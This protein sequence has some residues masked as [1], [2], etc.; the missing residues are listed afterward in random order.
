MNCSRLIAIV[1]IAVGLSA[2]AAGGS[3]YTGAVPGNLCYNGGTLGAVGS[4]TSSG[5]SGA[6][7]TYNNALTS[8][9]ANYWVPSVASTDAGI[10]ACS[11]T[12]AEVPAQHLWADSHGSAALQP[13]ISD[14][15]KFLANT[16][17]TPA[18]I[19]ELDTSDA[20]ND[21]S[22]IPPLP[23]NFDAAGPPGSA[24]HALGCLN[25]ESDWTTGVPFMEGKLHRT[26]AAFGNTYYYGDPHGGSSNAVSDPN[27]FQYF[28]CW[29]GGLTLGA[30][31]G[32][33]YRKW[34]NPQ[35]ITT[36]CSSFTGFDKYMC[37]WCSSPSSA[38]VGDPRTYNTTTGTTTA[39][40]A[41]SGFGY[42][43]TQGQFPGI[44]NGDFET[45]SLTPWTPSGVAPTIVAVGARSGTYAAQLGSL[46]PS[47]GDSTISQTFTVPAG[48]TTV[49]FWYKIVC[50]DSLT[51]DWFVAT[52]TDTTTS[53][54][55]TMVPKTCSNNGSWQQATAP[56]TAGHTVQL[57]LTSHG[58]LAGDPTYTLIDDVSASA[59]SSIFASWVVI[60]YPPM[61][62][63]VW[64]IAD[65]MVDNAMT[66]LTGRNFIFPMRREVRALT[67]SMPSNSCGTAS[68][69]LGNG[70]HPPCQRT[71]PFRGDS[72]YNSAFNAIDSQ[73]SA[74]ASGTAVGN[75]VPI[76]GG[77]SEAASA[78]ISG[79]LTLNGGGSSPS[80]CSTCAKNHIISIA[81][82]Q[83]C[84]DP[85]T[86]TIP[87]GNYDS[88]VSCS[89]SC[90]YQAPATVCPLR[91]G[92]ETCDGSPPVFPNQ[93]AS[94]MAN[95][96]LLPT[97]AGV[98][99]IATDAIG[100][101]SHSFNLQ[102]AAAAGGGVFVDAS[103]DPSAIHDALFSVL[104]GLIHASVTTA[105]TPINSVQATAG[106]EEEL[107][108]QFL[109]LNGESVWDGHLFKT[110]LFSEFASGCATQN[111]LV[112]FPNANSS[113]RQI[114][115]PCLGGKCNG[116][117]NVDLNN[118]IVLRAND[119]TLR[120]LSPAQLVTFYS[121]NSRVPTQQEMLSYPLFQPVW[122]TGAIMASASSPWY[123]RRTYTAID[124][125]GDGKIDATDGLFQIIAGSTSGVSNATA[126]SLTPYLGIVGTDVC[127]Q[128]AALNIGVTY[129]DPVNQYLTCAKAVLN[130]ALGQDLFDSNGNGSVIDNRTHML[131]DIYHSTPIDVGPPPQEQFCDFNSRRCAATLFNVY[132]QYDGA[133]YQV[134]DQP[135]VYYNDRGVLTSTP[136]ADSY[137][138]WVNNRIFNLKQSQ[139]RVFG[140]NDGWIHAIQFACFTGTSATG[141]PQYY[142]GPGST[143]CTNTTFSNGQEIW[144]FI[145]PDLLST[146]PRLLLKKH[147][148]FNDLTPMVRDIYSGTGATKGINDF[149][150]VAIFGERNGGT[151]WSALDVTDPANPTFRWLFPQIGSIDE[152]R[153]GLSW[154]EYFP[155]SPP[156]VPIRLNTSV[157][158]APVYNGQS[159]HETWVTALPGGYD[160][161]GGKGHGVWIV[162]AYTGKKYWEAFGGSGAQRGMDF[163][164]AAFPS[165][166]AWGTNESAPSGILNKGFFDTMVIGDVGGQ[167]WT[168]RFNDIPTFANNANGDRL[169]T[170]WTIARSFQQYKG[171]DLTSPAGTYV[172]KDRVPFFYMPSIGRMTD[173]GLMR[174][175][176]G[177]GDRGNIG[178]Q[179]LGDCSGSNMLACG[180]Q[181]VV[182]MAERDEDI[183]TSTLRG[184]AETFLGDVNATLTVSGTVTYTSSSV[185]QCTPADNVLNVCMSSS[186]G[187]AYTPPAPNQPQV[188]C[189]HTGNAASDEVCAR[190]RPPDL[191][192]GTNFNSATGSLNGGS[193]VYTPAGNGYYGRFYGITLFKAGGARALFSPTLANSASAYDTARVTESGATCSTNPAG[194]CNLW[195]NGLMASYVYPETSTSFNTPVQTDGASD[196]WYFYYP[197]IDERTASPSLLADGCLLW[198]TVQ[199]TS[200]CASDADCA[201]FSG[202]SSVASGQCNTVANECDRST[203]CNVVGGSSA[204]HI[205]QINPL[206]GSTACALTQSTTPRVT[207]GTILPPPPPQVDNEVNAQG[208]I[209]RSVNLPVGLPS[210]LLT[211][212]A[213]SGQLFRTFYDLEIPR[214][215]HD[216]RHNPG[217]NCQ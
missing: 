114:A 182:T 95:N 85:G 180:K 50:P 212:Q 172:M 4:A 148:A 199:P 83:T 106:G 108:P 185:T 48:A 98:Q 204:G 132:N 15:D 31:T 81:T 149:H 142:G 162:D 133:N 120:V 68:N 147:H 164:F 42:Y 184:G 71:N 1:G 59:N 128:L 33:Q 37:I 6:T 16:G 32:Y 23:D 115:C 80:W 210:T 72:S 159:F 53:S 119:G 25:S 26:W 161:F 163:P 102:Q 89:G 127:S 196:G 79:G 157:T 29:N 209:Q 207:F 169:A 197:N 167:L 22:T 111:G 78:Y 144:A 9:G 77:L 73:F 56:V 67:N 92:Q 58:D 183:G 27:N 35:P 75:D 18:A 39:N 62:M 121:A 168:A 131:G 166:V 153:A 54:S 215:Q 90:A 40:T 173:S 17:E 206:T 151:H 203:Q 105:S 2:S 124:T 107:I 187:S 155:G 24:G 65:F 171:D 178:D 91:T 82:G 52:I 66:D 211:P 38:T 138:A 28:G 8:F 174:A 74:Y 13:T 109:P 64:W 104:N 49:S 192:V 69:S 94:K 55:V 130:Y 99:S 176:V 21:F 205:Y 46:S 11:G 146:L 140:A 19:I 129:P 154:G 145:P 189:V 36:L 193:T 76:A 101:S 12:P 126:N 198:S 213:A 186:A 160:R 125:N 60:D 190:V 113:T 170:N 202:A 141:I 51:F 139:I 7:C 188:A 5:A 200:S 214:N 201:N 41:G 10:A 122:D 57:T 45:G 96:D 100:L 112:N 47:N 110:Y 87:S 137:E 175:F 143:G 34:G 152:L 14:D 194:L 43:L 195:P 103:Q 179:F 135:S 177:A 93:I 116:R 134:M 118:N 30:N 97:V 84:H 165:L 136:G 191:A 3:S 86:A 63:S 150:T 156:I 158:P 181:G 61:W 88:T 208:T 216:C 217:G 70:M 117:W 44:V 123:A 20:L